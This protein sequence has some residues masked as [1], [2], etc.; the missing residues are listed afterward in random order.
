MLYPEDF[1]EVEGI[2]MA[3]NTRGEFT[4]M[5]IIE[6][7]NGVRIVLQIGY[8][9]ELATHVLVNVATEIYNKGVIKQ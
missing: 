5:V 4:G 2:L 9:K 6:N 3:L 8:D 1:T 7:T